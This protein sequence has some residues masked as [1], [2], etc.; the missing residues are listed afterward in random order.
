MDHEEAIALLKDPAISV[1]ISLAYEFLE[2]SWGNDFYNT[3]HFYEV[4]GLYCKALQKNQPKAGELLI[5]RA[6][7]FEGGVA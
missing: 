7:S 5:D 3:T 4:P 2:A 6:R 1:E